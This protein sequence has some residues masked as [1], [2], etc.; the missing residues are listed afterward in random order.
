MNCTQQENEMS[1]ELSIGDM[2]DRIH[3]LTMALSLACVRISDGP[4]E[5]H[6]ANTPEGWRDHFI[7]KANAMP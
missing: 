4:Q 3:V 2:Q 7:A 5:Y 6:E 1:D